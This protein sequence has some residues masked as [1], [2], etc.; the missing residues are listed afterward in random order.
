[1]PRLEHLANWSLSGFPRAHPL[2]FIGLSSVPPDYLVRQQSNGQLRPTVN[3]TTACAVYS[4]KT[5]K[6]VCDDRSY[7][8]TVRCRKKTEDLNG[9]Q[10]QTP[11]VGS[12][13]THQ[14]MN[15]GV[16]GAPPDCPVWPS[17]TTAGIVVGAINTPN[18]HHS[19][20]PS[21]PTSSFNTRAKEYNPKTQSKHQILSKL[22]NQVK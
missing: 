13:G 16:S 17:T 11:T 9:K 19:S 22:Q 1:V 15:S 7:R 3:Y 4:T 12:R 5:Q 8:R 6:T 21:I 20:H 10:L 14:T 18:Q 2:K